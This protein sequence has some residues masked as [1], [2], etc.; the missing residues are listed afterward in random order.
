MDRSPASRPPNANNAASV[1]R[2]ALIAHWI[3]LDDRPRSCWIVGAAIATMVWSMNVIATA[4]I[5]A[6]KTRLRDRTPALPVLLWLIV[7]LLYRDEA[8]CARVRACVAPG[9]GRS[10][11]TRASVRALMPGIGRDLLVG[12]PAAV[13]AERDPGGQVDAGDGFGGEI[14][15]GEE[16]QVAWLPP[17]C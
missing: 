4:K 9:F 7:F 2:Y 6:V 13:E 14:L 10:E 11:A 12:D 15:G 3:P 16:D 1:S 8:A 5:I 17:A